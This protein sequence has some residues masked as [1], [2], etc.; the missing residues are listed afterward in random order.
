MNENEPTEDPRTPPDES[1]PFAEEGPADDL[2][3]DLDDADPTAEDRP[4]FQTNSTLSEL[5]AVGA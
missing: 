3:Q 4:A 1:E 5:P 2:L